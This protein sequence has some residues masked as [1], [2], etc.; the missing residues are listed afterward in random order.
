MGAILTLSVRRKQRDRK[1]GVK[2]ERGKGG[3]EERQRK[4]RERKKE[5]V[6]N[7]RG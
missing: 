4:K 7:A 3:G 2:G 1:T 6:A 5:G